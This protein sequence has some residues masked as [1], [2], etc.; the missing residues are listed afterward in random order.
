MAGSVGRYSRGL[1]PEVYQI[2]RKTEAQLLTRLFSPKY[3]TSVE[4]MGAGGD[5]MY[6]VQHRQSI[7]T[8]AY[9]SALGVSIPA[10][11]AINPKIRRQPSED[12]RK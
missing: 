4:V 9:Y 12:T 11:E 7:I 5:M 8:D 3:C 2:A 1:S 10:L 6:T